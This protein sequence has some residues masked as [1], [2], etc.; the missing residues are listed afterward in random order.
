MT[1]TAPEGQRL[2]WEVVSPRE[3]TKPE[4]HSTATSGFRKAIPASKLLAKKKKKEE[5]VKTAAE[6]ERER[7]AA[8]CI[9]L[10]KR[11]PRLQALHERHLF[12]GMP[13]ADAAAGDQ[14]ADQRRGVPGDGA[15]AGER[16]RHMLRGVPAD[17]QTAGEPAP[18]QWRGESSV[19]GPPDEQER[20]ARRG[21][22]TDEVRARD[23]RL[24]FDA[25]ESSRWVS[26][27]LE[28]PA[29]RA[30][31]WKREDY[32]LL[33]EEPPPARGPPASSSRYLRPPAAR[34][35]TLLADGAPRTEDG[36]AQAEASGTAPA[37]VVDSV[38]LDPVE[39]LLEPRA[40]GRRCA[41]EG[42]EVGRQPLSADASE[43]ATA[44]LRAGVEFNERHVATASRA[45]TLLSALDGQ[46]D[47]T[48]ES[49]G[50]VFNLSLD[51]VR[52]N[53]LR[54]QLA[55]KEPGRP[56][57]TPRK[58]KPPPPAPPPAAAPPPPKKKWTIY[59]SVW[60]DRPKTCDSRDFYDTDDVEAKKFNVDWKRAL[61]CGLEKFIV[62]KDDGDGE[63]EDGDGVCDEIDEARLV[64]WEHHDMLAQLFDYYA[65]LGGGAGGVHSMGVNEFGEFLYDYEMVSKEY[66]FCQ[67][68]DADLLFVTVDAASTRGEK[69]RQSRDL[70]RQG[71]VKNLKS[72]DVKKALDST[73]FLQVIARFGVMRYVMT[74]EIGD[75]S[76]AMAKL[77]STH[78]LPRLQPECSNDPNLFRRNICYT[79]LVDIPLKRH[80]TSLQRVFA[81]AAARDD[82]ARRLS[83]EQWEEL[84]RRLGFIAA[85]LTLRDGT[86]CFLSARMVKINTHTD[87][88]RWHQASLPFEGFLEAL[89]RVATL[90]AMPTPGEVAEAGCADAGEYMIKLRETEPNE[91][92]QIVETRG[93]PWGGD[94]WDGEGGLE[95]FAVQLEQV[96]TLMLRIIE[97]GTT[98]SDNLKL[99]EA[100]VAQ[101]FQGGRTSP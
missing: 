35:R 53:R 39:R 21:A 92:Q 38:P 27:I 57:P 52:R 29:T 10:M 67:R 34:T 64:L 44:T 24:L 51:D 88:G 45:T 85:D 41:L 75:V 83:L 40:A 84:L 69:E 13:A 22:P 25:M 31:N 98:G 93:M 70:K 5:V 73:E 95:R 76:E 96:L 16:R 82:D 46:H 4:T 42:G 37:V 72:L 18:H 8:Q 56:T 2:N 66:K 100:E 90:K 26:S 1:E 59:E 48:S 74:G 79:E 15:L 11:N 62:S 9:P 47:P 77:L 36:R 58:R 55:L 80:K 6:E 50:R 7:V 32:E 60:K 19:D 94:T 12:R 101:F 68:K 54:V 3:V 17:E 71:A 33:W 87:A 49:L 65:S 20:D 43:L 63:D 89:V 86:L 91:W 23:A 78:I 99:T 81:A 97:G 30:S 28:H 61:E 14:S